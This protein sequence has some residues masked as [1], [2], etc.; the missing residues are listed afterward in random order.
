[1]G[2]QVL[3]ITKET[4]GFVSSSNLRP[5][6]TMSAL[7]GSFDFDDRFDLKDIFLVEARPRILNIISVYPGQEFVFGVLDHLSAEEAERLKI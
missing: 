2:E 1:M 6:D 7:W 5:Q 4:I 3:A